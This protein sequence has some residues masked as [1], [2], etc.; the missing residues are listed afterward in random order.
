MSRPIS[1]SPAALR[2]SSLTIPALLR[3]LLLCWRGPGASELAACVPPRAGL[4]RGG[5]AAYV[6][7]LLGLAALSGLPGCTTPAPPSAASTAAPVAAAA[8]APNLATLE[9]SGTQAAVAQ[10]DQDIAAAGTNS[11]QLAPIARRLTA[12]LQDPQA[13]Y[14]GRQAA[15]QHLALFPADQLLAGGH[16]A[17]FAAMLLDDKQVDLARLAL[18]LVPGGAVDAMYLEALGAARGRPLLAVIQSVGNRRIAAATPVLANRL[19]DPA[20]AVADAAIKSL[21]Q[22]GTPDALTALR[23]FA[24]QGRPAVV[25][26]EL[27]AAG[28]LAGP[29]AIPVYTEI[30]N[31]STAPAG[32]RAAALRALLFAEPQG[33]TA[34]MVTILSGTDRVA[35]AAVIEALAALPDPGLVPALA[36][37]LSTWDTATQAAVVDALGQRGDSGALPAVLRATGSADATVRIAAIG[38]LGRLPGTPESAE[39]LGRLAAGGHTDDAK[40]ARESLARLAG[41]GVAEV[42]AANATRGETA[43]RVVFLDQIAERDMTA[44]VPLLLRMRSDPEAAVRSAALGALAEIAPASTQAALLDWAVAASDPTELPRALRALASV[45]L[46]NPDAAQ[47]CLPIITRIEQAPPAVAVRLMPVLPRV[48]GDAA[49]ACAGRLGLRPDEAEAHAAT[50]AL[51]AWASSVALEPLVQI[52][53]KAPAEAARTAGVNGAIRHLDQER[54]LASAELTALI[55]RLLAHT[56]DPAARKRLVYLLGRGSDAGAL[57]LAAQLHDD[58]ALA[59]VAADATMAIKANALGKPTVRV[60]DNPSHAADMLDGKPGTR[61]SAPAVAGQWIEIDLRATR[62]VSRLVLRGTDYDYPEHLEVFVTDDPAKRGA[63]VASIAG[64]PRTTTVSLPHPAHGRYLILENTQA[65]EGSW[66][67][68]SELLID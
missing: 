9:Y 49:I 8:P 17:A 27:V 16:R 10:L 45:T 58:A 57:A 41:P 11:R 18:D 25:E 30:A 5:G 38:A 52:A 36:A 44:Q 39:V 59:D 4:R 3:R 19:N 37:Q 6:P 61:W 53:E 50:A 23:A 33:A 43:I 42:V 1:E 21:G 29:G 15:A 13:T 46:R 34:R 40:L 55:R 56:Q 64:Q 22:I 54:T 7:F 63:A 35:K 31:R 32:L 2:T 48:G 68:V 24:D 12:L 62:P 26:A 67:G 14:A 20:P 51:A 47:R 66:W 60:S 65:R 28:H